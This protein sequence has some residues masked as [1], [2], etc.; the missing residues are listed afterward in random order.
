MKERPDAAEVRR[1]A[2][3]LPGGVHDLVS[4]RSRVYKNLGLADR[5]LT[6]DEWVDLLVREPG[7]WR[8]PIMIR[9]PHVVIGYD[10]EAITRLLS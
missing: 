1:L 7:L 2:A 5:S 8:R 9:G 6:A 3:L 10:Q 4:I